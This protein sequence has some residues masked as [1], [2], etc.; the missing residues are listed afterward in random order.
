MQYIWRKQSGWFLDFIA[1]WHGTVN[2]L[3]CHESGQTLVNIPEACQICPNFI[4]QSYPM[5]QSVLKMLYWSMYCT[6]VQNQ[7]LKF[8]FIFPKT[9][10]KTSTISFPTT[11]YNYNYNDHHHHH[12]YYYFFHYCYYP[13][14]AHKAPLERPRSF[15]FCVIPLFVE[16]R[17]VAAPYHAA[18]RPSVK[19]QWANDTCSAGEY[20][21]TNSCSSFKSFNV[22]K[23]STK[24][25]CF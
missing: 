3:I 22:A 12:R 11:N 17:C 21:W 4:L 24:W 23:K 5:C 16:A 19:G 25:Q 6:N 10:R 18:H 20:R 13:K 15:L 7:L 9:R 14:I 8:H 2:A 1:Q